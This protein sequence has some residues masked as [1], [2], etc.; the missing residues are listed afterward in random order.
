VAV[1]HSRITDASIERLR[2]G[3]K[4]TELLARKAWTSD[5]WAIESIRPSIVSVINN[6]DT[7]VL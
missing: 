2:L 7:R 4:G 6:N 5:V 3:G 1:D